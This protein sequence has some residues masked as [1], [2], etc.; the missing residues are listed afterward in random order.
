M[1]ALAGSAA[2]L[3]DVG[4]YG[5]KEWLAILGSLVGIGGSIFG[6]WRA[7]RYSKKQIAERLLEF[8]R[9]EE[10]R[11]V[12]GRSR[13][14]R[15]LRVGET[16]GDEPDHAFYHDLKGTLEELARG[17]VREAEKRLDTFADVWAHDVKV[18]QKFLSNTNM[19]LATALLI[20][21]NIAKDRSERS[22]ARSAWEGALHA[23]PHDCEAARYLGE[24][25]LA[26]DDIDGALEYFSKAQ[27]LAPDDNMLSAETWQLVADFYQRQGP[28]KSELRA[29][30]LCAPDFVNAGAWGQAAA[31]YARAGEIAGDFGQSVQGPRLLR[32]AFD[33]YSL[34]GDRDGMRA[35]RQKLESLGDDV[36]DLGSVEQPRR[37]R[38]PWP[39][40]RLALEVSILAA[41]AG[42]F[43]FSLR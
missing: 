23:F 7:W 37:R 31:A 10:A 32:Q 28:R 30:N 36:S 20:R 19:Q 5:I 35:V 11:I 40:I 38:D 42:L 22:A 41:A 26:A 21:G 13:V 27:A 33:N 14:I 6:V 9:D 1:W 3:I 18:G 8:L 16:L 2:L 34:A 4:S 25:A 12:E 17:N 39:W 43:Y 15:H 29:L 24:L